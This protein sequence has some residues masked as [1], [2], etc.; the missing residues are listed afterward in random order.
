MAIHFHL[1][2]ISCIFIN[3]INVK[4]LQINNDVLSFIMP[5]HS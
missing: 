1:M 5:I 2:A 4:K 3:G